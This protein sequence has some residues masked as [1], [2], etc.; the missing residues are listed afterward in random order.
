MEVNV[1]LYLFYHKKG[2]SDFI[3]IGKDI[4]GYNF[5]QI[6]VTK[7]EN[8]GECRLINGRFTWNALWFPWYE[9][10]YHLKNVPFVY[11][12]S[13]HCHIAAT[14]CGLMNNGYCFISTIVMLLHA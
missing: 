11:N 14:T 4:Y 6:S 7:G 10:L 5:S 2:V 9:Q 1:C 13:I 8:V 3:I 12:P